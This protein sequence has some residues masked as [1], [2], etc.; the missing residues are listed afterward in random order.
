VGVTASIVGDGSATPYHLVLNSSKTGVA[1]SLKISS[2]GDA[3][4]ANLLNYDPSGTQNFTE[5]SNAQNANL[6]V[7]GINITSAANTVTSSLPGVT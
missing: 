7:N 3:T 4:I 2:T 1:S 6:K 5:I